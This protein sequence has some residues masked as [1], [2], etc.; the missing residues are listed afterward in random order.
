MSTKIYCHRCA[1]ALSVIKPI[2]PALPSL[3]GS[4]YQFEKF[5]KHT[6]PSDY[7]GLVSVFFTNEYPI[8]RDYTISG[9]LSGSVQVDIFNR[10]NLVW[11]AGKQIGITYNN[12]K[13]EM[14]T[15]AVKVVL[16]EN[17]LTIHAFPVNY[18]LQYINRCLCCGNIIPT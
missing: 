7:N 18:T 17:D 5:T 9:T 16:S 6:A 11:Y 8:Y 12:G 1:V 13:Y 4:S 3:T 15:D 14:P 2:D 10:K